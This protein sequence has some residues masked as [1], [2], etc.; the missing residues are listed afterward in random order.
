MLDLVIMGNGTL[1][2]GMDFCNLNNVAL[3]D[4]P[5]VGRT[6]YV[7]ESNFTNIGVLNYQSK[8]GVV[9]GT[10]NAAPPCY[11]PI[12]GTI[13]G[14]TSVYVGET[15]TMINTTPG[16]I[17]GSSDTSI[18]S[19]NVFGVVTG[20]G[21]GSADVNYT[22]IADCGI[23]TTVNFT[24]N[25][26][27][28]SGCR[29]VLA[30]YLNAV[31]NGGTAT[32]AV[33]GRYD[34]KLVAE[35]TF[36]NSYPLLHEYL[37]DAVNGGANYFKYEYIGQILASL[38]PSIFVTP[39]ATMSSREVDI[40]NI[41]YSMADYLVI[42]N[43]GHTINSVTFKD[44]MGNKAICAPV[45]IMQSTE[46]DIYNYWIGDL[47]VEFIST[48]GEYAT[49][50]LV[51]SSMGASSGIIQNMVWLYDAIG[52]TPDPLD[53]T[54]PDLTYIRLR[55]GKYHFGVEVTYTLS[56]IP[57]TYPSKSIFSIAVEVY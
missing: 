4:V 33:I 41:P 20:V 36:V 11:A 50:L 37:I 42:W 35:T 2:S 47:T 38:P 13:S 51:R 23:G 40:P 22:V 57:L 54:N 14:P 15:I 5:L 31:Y 30:P 12:V 46:A 49:L 45:I 10:L 28:V 43:A 18:F 32:P 27:A 39:P 9:I 16:G 29:V 6:Y 1:E 34:Y 56:V 44:I 25:V 52:G 7:P 24:I 48:D 19:I 8:N 55:A 17:W 3:S 26:I 53:P 21:A